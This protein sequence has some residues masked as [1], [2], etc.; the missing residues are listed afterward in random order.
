MSK[1]GLIT[2]EDLARMMHMRTLRYNFEDATIPFRFAETKDPENEKHSE[3]LVFVP[4][5]I[6]SGFA[7][8][9][10]DMF[11]IDLCSSIFPAEP[12]IRMEF[13]RTTNK[14]PAGQDLFTVRSVMRQASIT[15]DFMAGPVLDNPAIQGF[16]KFALSQMKASKLSLPTPG[17]A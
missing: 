5:Y 2:L 14:C 17:K 8:G 15:T 12:M 11:R 16:Y 4:D 1:D 7:P 6:E 10:Y 3:S 13:R 9:G